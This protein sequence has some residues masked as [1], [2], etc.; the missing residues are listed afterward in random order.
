[1][2]KKAPVVGIDLGTTYSCVAYVDEAGKAVV[3]KNFDN[4][5]ITPSVVL[6]EDDNVVVGKV[7]KE[8]AK[9]E[10]ENVVSF[11][12][13]KMGKEYSFAHNGKSY[14]P[15]EISAY[16]L[17]KLVSDSNQTLG[18]EITDAVITVPA[19][20]GISEREATARA[21]KIAGLNVLEIINE[22]TAAAISYGL[23][24]LTG[25]KIILV[26]DL[27][28]GT[29]DVTLMKVTPES[30]EVIVTDGH[31][32]LGGKNWDDRII[33]HM[34]SQFATR[35]DTDEDDLFNDAQTM[36]DFQDGAERSIKKRLSV[37]DKASYSAQFGKNREKIEV[38]RQEFDDLTSDLLQQTI[39]I[40]RRALEAAATKGHTRFDEIILVGGS[41][42]MPQIG[43]AVEKAFGT[44]PRLF[45]PDE[46]VARGAAIVAH[47][48]A[49]LKRI[50]EA[51]GTAPTSA[52]EV[53]N[54]SED[55]RKT[56]EEIAI[57]QGTDLT[58][59]VS[60]ISITDKS[61]CA[62]S[63]GMVSVD[64]AGN[65][66]VTNL[67]YRNSPLP[68]E[69]EK[70][71]VTFHE[72][73]IGVDIKVVENEL[74]VE[75]VEVEQSNE[76]GF[77]VLSFGRPMPKNTPIE[78]KFTLKRDGTLDIQATE[79]T[80]GNKV[81]VTIQTTNVIQGQELEDAIKRSALMAVH[82]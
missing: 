32:E 22:P 66:Q 67:I 55:D 58:T 77:G 81:D 38:S 64:A 42:R 4:E 62:K 26:F 14:R 31:N 57:S 5:N 7:A 78:V 69:V 36:A 72:G 63:F 47:N 23:S 13:R 29:F 10:P 49:L 27:G 28:G 44:K 19:Y 60:S 40:T 53:Q 70:P 75:V 50:Q 11:I 74:S 48:R 52:E 20:F 18:C 21:G 8:S 46:A 68:T 41:C 80:T 45:D 35:T 65:P 79:R 17:K 56:L 34:V 39:D 43:L 33:R 82:S 76:I 24:D 6:F 1:M 71:F 12:K 3:V 37:S 59:L 51:I 61:V 15:E 30:F 25:E 16:I 54:L 73:Q 2:S 9:L